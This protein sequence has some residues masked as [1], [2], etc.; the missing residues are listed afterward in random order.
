MPRSL[1]LKEKLAEAQAL[2]Y[3]GQARQSVESLPQDISTA[4]RN[5][6][7]TFLGAPSDLMQM[8]VDFSI[9][10]DKVL[11]NLPPDAEFMVPFTSDILAEQFG[12][13]T[14]HRSF[15]PAQFLTPGPGEL[16]GAAKA[17]FGAA[18]AIKNLGKEKLAKQV[19]K[20]LASGEDPV[21]VLNETGIYKDSSGN[22]RYWISDV[23]TTIDWDHATRVAENWV[24]KNQGLGNWGT[25]VPFRLG[26]VIK[27]KELFEA[28]PRFKDLYITIPFGRDI[29]GNII[30]KSTREVGTGI[31]A[32]FY[33]R[34]KSIAL[35]NVSNLETARGSILHE[36][37]HLIDTVEGFSNGANASVWSN[38]VTELRNTNIDR[39]LIKA[40][41]TGIL[42]ANI[43]SGIDDLTDFVQL[44]TIAPEKY[45]AASKVFNA[46]LEAS[47]EPLRVEE[48]MEILRTAKNI[49]SMVSNNEL[50]ALADMKAA[51]QMDKDL[52]L[53]SLK[54]MM[55]DL[56]EAG[57]VDPKSI[58]LIEGLSS[59]ELLELTHQRYLI[60]IGEVRG[61]MADVL[62]NVD[63]ATSRQVPTE[64]EF[65][66][67]TMKNDQLLPIEDA[68]VR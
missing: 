59:Q 22:T 61:R 25:P 58:D 11:G 52:S 7:A 9:W 4:G 34:D 33:P 48:S 2:G 30:R 17:G 62:R 66:Q 51:L 55:G 65:L 53:A 28:Y 6:A 18:I 68:Q 12:G 24:P 54:A 20:R 1:T 60:N 8:G 57:A 14:E 13:S 67:K 5:I 36:V 29:D 43:M 40:F 21:Q 45:A 31:N 32:Q 16:V 41:E 35:E 39:G 47:G 19:E 38:A 10:R 3:I 23:D 49:A 15:M 56:A 64:T 46:L 26:S 37:Q 27:N 42:D 44:K 63:P 50:G